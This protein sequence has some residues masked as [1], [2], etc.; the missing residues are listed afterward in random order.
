M[1]HAPC[2]L[3]VVLGDVAELL[4][5]VRLR[6]DGFAEVLPNLVLVDV[7]GRHELDVADVIAP[8]HG[9]HETGDESVF[10]AF[11]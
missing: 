9:V 4:G 10:L 3:D 1:R 6:E 7:D 11:L 8:D 2:H 5:V